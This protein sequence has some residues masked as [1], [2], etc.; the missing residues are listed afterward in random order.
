MRQISNQEGPA[1]T[2]TLCYTG[3]G[4][5]M[6]LRNRSVQ[7]TWRVICGTTLAA[8]TRAPWGPGPGCCSTH[9]NPLNPVLV[10]TVKSGLQS[11]CADPVTNAFRPE[12]LAVTTCVTQRQQFQQ[13]TRSSAVSLNILL[14]HSRSFETTV[15]Q[16]VCKS[17]LVFHLN[18]VCISYRC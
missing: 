13:T 10:T 4:A 14:S 11:S 12:A 3:E 16:G 18:Y 7:A 1:Y 2:L 8:L 6:W 5:R 15:E 17:L 9:S